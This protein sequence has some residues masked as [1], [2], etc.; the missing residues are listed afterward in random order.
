MGFT[1]RDKYQKLCEQELKS[2]TGRKYALMLSQG[3]SALI[4]CLKSLKLPSNTLVGVSY[5]WISCASS[6]IH[7]GYTPVFLDIDEDN[8]VLG[9]KAITQITQFDISVVMFVNMLGKKV[10]PRFLHYCNNN[11]I[12]IVE[13]ATH[14]LDS[15]N[16]FRHSG[17]EISAGKIGL[18]CT[19][20][21]K[22]LQASRSRFSYRLP[23]F[24]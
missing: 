9:S 12:C 23:R 17:L 18:L 14:S 15:D 6:I 2:L 22:L 20:L 11:D 24:I 21:L 4:T 8:C 5:S 16:S 13:D 10:S 19:K 3:T 1:Q 7:A